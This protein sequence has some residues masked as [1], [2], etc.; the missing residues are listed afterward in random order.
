MGEDLNQAKL[1]GYKKTIKFV[2]QLDVA[3]EE[4]LKSMEPGNVETNVVEGFQGIAPVNELE[5]SID[6]KIVEMNL[7]ESQVTPSY[8]PSEVRS[9]AVVSCRLPKMD[10]PSL[11]EIHFS[12]KDFQSSKIPLTIVSH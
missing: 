1:I 9:S 10:I 5:A 12:G 7:K 11:R 8:S 2:Q 3:N 4:I 6:V